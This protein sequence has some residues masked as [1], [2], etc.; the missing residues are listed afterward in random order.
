MG[1]C[2]D[3]SG[4]HCNP[5]LIIDNDEAVLID[6]GSRPEFPQVMMKVLKTG[7]NPHH[8]RALIYQHFDPD[9]CGSIPNLENIISNKDLRI[10]S[11]KSNNVFIK[12]YYVT[13]GLLSID[14]IDYKFKFQSG[15]E[16]SFYKT[17]YAHAPGSFVTFDSK[18]GILFTSDLFGSYGKE[19]E[20]FLTL[21]KECFNCADY[22][23][24]PN[25]KDYCPIPDLLNFHK[26]VIPS[27]EALKQAIEVVAKV[28]LSIIAPQHGSIIH[29]ADDIAFVCEKLFKLDGVGIDKLAHNR[30]GNDSG[31]IEGLKRRLAQK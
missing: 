1:F 3:E 26:E 18:S 11:E 15:R 4:L 27:G 9:L 17:P 20:L 16:L 19:W 22:N 13:S 30:A 6:G 24:C 10:I 14:E 8:I 31:S 5:Y 23:D 2:D 21:E 7:V 25:K 29:K 12:H 28:P